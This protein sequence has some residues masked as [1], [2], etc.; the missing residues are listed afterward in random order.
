[1]VER[2]ARFDEATLL[3]EAQRKA[4]LSDFGDMGF[5]APLRVLLESLADAPLNDVGKLV[6]RTSIRR[7][8]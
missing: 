4:G 5:Q 3:A 1:M 6:L 7:S 8:P 2:P